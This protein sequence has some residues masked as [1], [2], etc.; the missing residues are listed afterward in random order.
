[1]YFSQTVGFL[2]VKGKQIWDQHYYFRYNDNFYTYSV[3]A[4]VQ[5]FLSDPDLKEKAFRGNISDSYLKD[6]ASLKAFI[7]A[8][9][10]PETIFSLSVFM[11][12][13]KP[14]KYDI[15]TWKGVKLVTYN[16]IDIKINIAKSLVNSI[17][18][19]K[20]VEWFKKMEEHAVKE[21]VGRAND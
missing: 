5:K 9:S 20:L 7:E 13:K 3:S 16:Q 4:D 8:R 2:F 19:K 6:D 15:T 18:Q 17:L 12:T 11:A 10:D 1:M 21:F 14:N